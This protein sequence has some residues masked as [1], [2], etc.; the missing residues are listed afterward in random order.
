MARQVNSRLDEAY[1]VSSRHL[2]ARLIA[3]SPVSSSHVKVY[4]VLG[5]NNARL[6]ASWQAYTTRYESLPGQ[7]GPVLS[8]RV[9]SAHFPSLRCA[10]LQVKSRFQSPGGKDEDRSV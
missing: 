1:R 9:F 10:S 8:S 5:A 6:V 7:S 3:S 2:R 4:T